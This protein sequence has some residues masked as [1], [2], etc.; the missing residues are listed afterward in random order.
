MP[1]NPLLK[2]IPR[3]KPKVPDWINFLFWFS[4]ILLLAVI[5]ISF[6]LQSQVSFLDKKEEELD[7]QL[8]KIETG[9]VETLEKEVFAVSKKIKDFSRLFKERKVISGI[10]DFF[11]SQCHPKV[12]FATFSLTSE[13]YQVNLNGQT[14]SFRTLGEQVLSFKKNENI[15]D[16]QLFNVSFNREGKVVFT[17]TFSLAEAIF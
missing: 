10:F 9:D 4:L 17:V 7:N 14:E 13:N 6:Y 3:A 11:R 8:T 16:F 15:K 1:K 2:I 12:Q 5:S